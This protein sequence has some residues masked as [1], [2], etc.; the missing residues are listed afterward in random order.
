M[1]ERENIGK[2]GVFKLRENLSNWTRNILDSYRGLHLD[3]CQ[4]DITDVV[5]QDSL[6]FYKAHFNYCRKEFLIPEVDT[7]VLESEKT[8]TEPRQVSIHDFFLIRDY[9]LEKM[10]NHLSTTPT[11]QEAEGLLKKLEKRLDQE[12]SNLLKD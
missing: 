2:K 12:I 7:I 3:L 10:G 5:A 1:K 9:L 4:F 11:Y 8:V 6:I